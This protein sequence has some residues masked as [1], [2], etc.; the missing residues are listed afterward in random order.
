[1]KVFMFAP[2][3]RAGSF[4]KKLIRIAHSIVKDHPDIDAELCEF[5]DFPMP[6]YDGD[7]ETGIGIPAGVEKLAK[8][9]RDADAII[10]SS[11]EYNGSIPGTLKNAIDWLSRLDPVPVAG[12]QVLTMGASTGQFAAIKGNF[13]LRVPFHVLNAFVYPEYFGVAFS[14]TAFDEK[15]KLKDPKQ[16]ERLHRILGEFLHYASRKE[17]PFDHLED[18]FKAQKGTIHPNL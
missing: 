16:L 10:I 8:K 5:N 6:M 14:E 2:V 3:L 13:H 4:N 11:P 15:G 1:M 12:K 18:F 9:I 17:T 7:I